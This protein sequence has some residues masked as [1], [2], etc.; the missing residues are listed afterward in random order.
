[1]YA[2]G[3]LAVIV[4]ANTP[5]S[6]PCLFYLVFRIPCPACGLT[7]A[8]VMASRFN[9]VGAVSMNILFLPIVVGGAAFFVGAVLDFF[10]GKDLV[11]WL[12]LLL[13]RWWVIT[14][15][16]VLMLTSWGI[17]IYRTLVLGIV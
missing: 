1:M 15:A 13:A 3:V 14:L 5:F 16:A 17:N 10:W 2:L 6:V 11:N 4:T 12:N 7:R 9:F 8:F